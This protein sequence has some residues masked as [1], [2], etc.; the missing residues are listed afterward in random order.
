[1]AIREAANVS[2]QEKSHIADHQPRFSHGIN[3][4]PSHLDRPV[5]SRIDGI[6][7]VANALLMVILASECRLCLPFEKQ[8]EN[9]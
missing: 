8:Q 9:P 4:M 5:G 7:A 3:V 6:P 2:T 1:M